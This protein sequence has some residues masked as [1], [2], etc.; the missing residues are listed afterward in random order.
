VQQIMRHAQPGKPRSACVTRTSSA[1]DA[2]GSRV[3]RV[4]N[5]T[6]AWQLAIMDVL[7]I[8]AFFAVYFAL[9][10]WILPRFGVGT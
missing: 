8:A 9:Q 6:P 3:T 1:S 2:Q 5:P 7:L 10:L 4:A